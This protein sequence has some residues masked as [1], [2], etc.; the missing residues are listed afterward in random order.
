MGN[1]LKAVATGGLSLLPGSAGKVAGSVATG[2]PLFG[3]NVKKRLATPGAAVKPGME[4]GMKEGPAYEKAMPGGLISQLVKGR[5]GAA[6]NPMLGQV[7]GNVAKAMGGGAFNPPGP[8]AQA[9][10]QIGQRVNPAEVATRRRM[11]Y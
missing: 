11:M 6:P 5:P 10:A 2:L 3:G 9:N 7:A 8:P 4:M 1:A